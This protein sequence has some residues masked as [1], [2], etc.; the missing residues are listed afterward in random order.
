MKERADANDDVNLF[1]YTSIDSFIEWPQLPSRR[2]RTGPN[3]T[4]HASAGRSCQVMIIWGESG[5]DVSSHWPAYR[6]HYSLWEG[7]NRT[8]YPLPDIQVLTPPS[9]PKLQVQRG[10]KI[11]FC[12][13]L[14]SGSL[15]AYT[16]EILEYETRLKSECANT[17]V[18]RDVCISK[19]LKTA[20]IYRQIQK[21]SFAA[22]G[23]I[24]HLK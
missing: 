19:R 13:M 22:L 15:V 6:P 23:S 12:T 18:H 21:F 7:R 11:K 8:A 2:M 1:I 20:I 10:I 3:R 16:N 4:A 17:L 5:T 14:P 9:P 24:R